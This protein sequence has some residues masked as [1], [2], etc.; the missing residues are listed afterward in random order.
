MDPSDF[1]WECEE[2]LREIIEAL[3]DLIESSGD[4]GLLEK[5]LLVI[6]PGTSTRG[7]QIPPS[8][9]PGIAAMR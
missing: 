2:K 4:H 7:A 5:A 9:D 3:M 8:R 1:I 6:S